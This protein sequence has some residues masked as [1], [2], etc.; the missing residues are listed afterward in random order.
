MKH[1]PMPSQR[2]GFATSAVNGKIYLIGGT[3]WDKWPRNG[4]VLSTVEEYDPVTNQWKRRA[5]MRIGRTLL[6][7][8]AVNG[9][10]YAIGGSVQAWWDRK[11]LEEFNPAMDTWEKKADMLEPRSGFTANVVDGKIYV[12]GGATDGSIEVYDPVADSWERKAM[13]PEW[14]NALPQVL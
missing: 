3:V 14:R 1:T 6:A 2:V 4:R 8:S 12:I 10:I 13:M 11:H 9:K 7:T 5:N